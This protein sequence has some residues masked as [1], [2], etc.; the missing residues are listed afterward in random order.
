[1]T[2]TIFSDNELH[3][4][5]EALTFLEKAAARREIQ[6]STPALALNFAKVV[7]DS[8]AILLL[9]QHGFYLQ[10]A[11]VARSTLDACN[12][13]MHI[14]A[15]GEETTIVEQWLA[16]HRMTHWMLLD[17]LNERLKCEGLPAINVDNYRQLRRRLDDLVHANYDALKLYPAQLPGP[18][19]DRL[20]DLTFW[21]GLVKL[22]LVVC[23]LIV[24]LTVPDLQ[25]RAATHLD[26]LLQT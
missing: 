22:Y 1:M 5:S 12:L 24:R 7:S 9:M 25:E 21:A 13:L 2:T 14:G 15:E 3:L 18:A 4:Y 8:R 11:I 16:G 23:L 19:D 20:R 6:T 17:R 26:G 10:A